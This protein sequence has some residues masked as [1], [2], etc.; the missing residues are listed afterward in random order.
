MM[1]NPLREVIKRSRML[2]SNGWSPFFSASNGQAILASPVNTSAALNNSDVFAVVYRISSDVASCRI[3]APAFVDVLNHPMGNLMNGYNVWQAVVAQMALNGNAYM[4]IHRDNNGAPV[5]LE[6][7]PEDRITVTLNDDGSDVFYTVHFDDSKRSG[8]FN[9][10]SKDMLHFR[11]FVNGQSESQYMGVSPLMSL[12]KE[13]DVQDQSNR[14]ALSALKH[15]LAPTNIL[16]VPQGMLNDDSKE[17]IRNEFEKANSGEN[18]GRAI[19]LDQGL[20]LSQLT[21]SPDIAKLLDNTN[22]SQAQIAKAFCVPAD[23]L[24]GKQDEQSSIEQV[25]SLYQNSL[26]LYIRPVEDEL[27]NKLGVPVH[28]DVSTAVD[29]DHQQLIGNIVNLTNSTNPVLSG[30]DARQILVDRGVLPKQTY[31]TATPGKQMETGGEMSA[32]DNRH[33][34]ADDQ[35]DDSEQRQ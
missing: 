14:L 21:V 4:L 12:A 26:T 28:L 33:Q 29:I 1:F 30:D 2:N 31:Q 17:N 6:P 22:F 27:S 25:R 34:N 11:L 23:Y 7:V 9:V 15:A 24:S 5:R 3:I 16:S 10:M 13:I 18:A 8:D 20:S 32:N 35:S 19:V